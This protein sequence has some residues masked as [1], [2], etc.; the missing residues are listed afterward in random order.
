MISNPRLPEPAP[1]IRRNAGDRLRAVLLDLARGQAK[2]TTHS[3]RNWASITFA[4]ARH[5]LT[6]EF[7][8][9]EAVQAGEL[10]I[11]LLPDHEFAIPG[12]LVADASIIA[13]DHRLEPP[14]MQVSCELLVLE[15]A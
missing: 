14:W 12:Q 5:R 4:G 11:A 7:E 10:F 15:D 13:V 3:E 6:L 8:G 9:E 1:R 2:I